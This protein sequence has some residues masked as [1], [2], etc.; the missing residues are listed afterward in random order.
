VRSESNGRLVSQFASGKNIAIKRPLDWQP[1]VVFIFW[2]ATM[3]YM[4]YSLHF[5]AAQAA[6]IHLLPSQSIQTSDDQ[7]TILSKVPLG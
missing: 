3:K 2:P 4:S 1:E 6:Q 5:I 7:P